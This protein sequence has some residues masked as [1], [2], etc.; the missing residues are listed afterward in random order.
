[1]LLLLLSGGVG[2]ALVLPP[3]AA[4]A[5]VSGTWRRDPT[6]AILCAPLSL[7]LAGLL[8]SAGGAIGYSAPLAHI[9]AVLSLLSLVPVLAA[10]PCLL[11]PQRSFTPVMATCGFP[12]EVAAVALL[13][14]RAL[15]ASDL[16]IPAAD[17]LIAAATANFTADSSGGDGGDGGDG[18][19]QQRGE[20][21]TANTTVGLGDATRAEAS[22]LLA[23]VDLAAWGQLCVASL[24]VLLV[25][26]RFALAA[27]R[28]VCRSA[29][30]EAEQQ[31]QQQ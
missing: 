8:A 29:S 22:T 2:C 6:S 26:T 24:V 28:G 20:D 17:G 12:M 15:V 27:A 5:L 1:M 10:M 3:L 25:L 4:K 23:L 16:N 9:L 18:N 21:G 11:G 30:R 7:L 31:Q 13:R 14:Y 19:G